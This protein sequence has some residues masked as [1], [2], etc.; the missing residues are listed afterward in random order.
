MTGVQ[1]CALPIYLPAAD[2]AEPELSPADRRA[3]AAIAAA[4][5]ASAASHGEATNTGKPDDPADNPDPGD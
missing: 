5:A 2:N 4:N 3:A 1:T